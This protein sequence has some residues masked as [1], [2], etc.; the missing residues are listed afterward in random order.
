MDTVISSE[1]V[2]PR[3]DWGGGGSPKPAGW[4]ESWP[5]SILTDSVRLKVSLAGTYRANAL[6]PHMWFYV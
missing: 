1:E 6:T 4:W 5:V 2:V 3:T